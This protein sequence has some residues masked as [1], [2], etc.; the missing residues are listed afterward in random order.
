MRSRREQN[1]PISGAIA[2]GAWAAEASSACS[3]PAAATCG[4]WGP[5]TEAATA[6]YLDVAAK[7]DLD[8]SQMAIA[9][10]L[11]RPFMTSAIIGATTMDQLKTCIGAKDVSLSD[12]VMEDIAKVRRNHP[13]PM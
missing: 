2:A 10:C 6:A 8:P 4:R 9:F 11:T 13:M 1:R 5:A 3:R 7:H 12:A